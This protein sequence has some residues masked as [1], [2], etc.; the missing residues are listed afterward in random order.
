MK[1][2]HVV[3]VV[4]MLALAVP[5]LACSD[6]KTSAAT[7]SADHA[8]CANKAS[9]AV[10]AGAWLE[11]AQNGAVRV[12]DVAKN[13]PAARSGLKAG[14]VVVAVN[15]NKIA[16]KGEC[17][18]T[19]EECMIGS[20]VAYT[21]Q[22]GRSTKVMKLKLEKMPA[23]ATARFADREASFDPMLATLVLTSN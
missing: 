10:W 8:C 6:K 12:A 9:A 5:A 15:G 14:D 20:S 16:A 22:R 23:T 3:P 18:L 19:H 1:I 11:R 2:K 17:S 13:S 21:V 7:A 4:L